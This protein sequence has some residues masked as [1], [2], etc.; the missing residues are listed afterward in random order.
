MKNWPGVMDDE[1]V[2]KIIHSKGIA[3]DKQ[4]EVM[5]RAWDA[6]CDGEALRWWADIRHIDTD[7]DPWDGNHD[8]LAREIEADI[9]SDVCELAD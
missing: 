8:D 6:C 7:I 9:I 3:D 2:R 1:D 5:R 4:A